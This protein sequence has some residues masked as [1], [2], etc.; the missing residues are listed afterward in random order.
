VAGAALKSLELS[1]IGTAAYFVLAVQLYRLVAPVDRRVAFLLLPLAAL[2]CVIQGV[3][4]IEA[5]GGIQ[6]LAL[7]FFALFL[8]ALGYLVARSGFMPRVIGVYLLLAGIAW[9]TAM[10]PGMP[11]PIAVVLMAFGA[12]AELVLALWLLFGKPLALPS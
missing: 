5:D 8:V 1:L 4:M 10:I 3:G 11:S 7:V 6:R 9:C 12:F 2:G